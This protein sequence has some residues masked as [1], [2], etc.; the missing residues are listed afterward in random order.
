M[1]RA[2]SLAFLTFLAAAFLAPAAHA[3][4]PTGI[5][6][7]IDRVAILPEGKAPERL[8]VFGVFML[9][10]EGVGSWDVQDPR[11]GVLVF[12]LEKGK[13]EAHLKEWKDLSKLAGT[14]K[15]AA[16]GN[17]WTQKVKLRTPA[18]RG[19]GAPDVYVTSVGVQVMAK[20]SLPRVLQKLL[21][22]RDALEPADGA[23]LP[24]GGVTLRLRE[25]LAAGHPGAKVYFELEGPGE[26]GR[27]RMLMASP[28]IA[29]SPEPVTWA[30]EVQLAPGAIYIC[31]AWAAGDGWKSATRTTTF[32]V[33]G[34][35]PGVKA[36]VKVAPKSPGA[37]KVPAER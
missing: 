7:L 2:R 34:A 13:E 35:E 5:Y 8:E 22:Y 29:P 1:Y 36:P 20:D 33:R 37:E 26:P 28:G 9:V 24:A 27:K 25:N 31:R 21:E 32:T 30:P 16:F 6:G 17:R 18:E 10:K 12:Q 19:E 15:V 14:G 11:R 23:E 3:S 4:Q